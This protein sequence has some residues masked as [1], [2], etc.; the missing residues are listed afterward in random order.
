VTLACANVREW[1]LSAHRL[2][3]YPGGVYKVIAA[4]LLASVVMAAPAAGA[5]PDVYLKIR[6]W[7]NGL[8]QPSVS[9]RLVCSAD[10]E[11]EGIWEGRPHPSPVRACEQV[12]RL[13]TTAFNPVPKAAV[14]AR[15]S[16]RA[17]AHVAGW[18]DGTVWTWFRR[19]DSCQIARW[20]L[21]SWLLPLRNGPGR[22]VVQQGIAG[23]RLGMSQAQVKAKV[24][25]PRKV[26]RLR[27]EIGPFTT[28]RYRTYSVTFFAGQRV[29]QLSTV[30]R[31]ERTAQG[32]SVGS[33]IDAVALVAG[34][35]CLREFG[36][37]HCY[38]GRWVPGGKVTDFAIKE[39]R[40]VRISIGYVID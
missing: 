29:T 28:Y 18:A 11:L 3:Q 26:E 16:D 19:N 13:R 22:V 5:I 33:P 21:H 1:P 39:G 38:V 27:N 37:D 2:V 14:C 9:Y 24:G 10:P 17:V 6:V 7:P 31:K 30:S 34:A 40:V 23:L 36:Y 15:R 8:N 4:A 20:D 25:L 12:F 35:K 32:I